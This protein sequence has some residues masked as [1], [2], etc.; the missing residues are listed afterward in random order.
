MLALGMLGVLTS[1]A[2]KP[3]K[4][5]AL[6]YIINGSIENMPTGMLYLETTE[7]DKR[8]ID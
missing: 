7:E 1:C 6:G 2:E 3:E 5:E 8:I 4:K